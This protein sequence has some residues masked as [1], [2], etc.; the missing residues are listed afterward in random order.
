MISV[1]AMLGLGIT[2]IASADTVWWRTEGGTVVELRD[3]RE[4][5]LFLTD[6]DKSHGVAFTW[7]LDLERIGIQ[8]DRL[9]LSDGQTA[10]MSVRIG[11]TPIDDFVAVGTN[12]FASGVVTQSTEPLLRSA[13]KIT[14]RVNDIELQI[15]VNQSKMPALLTAVDKCRQQQR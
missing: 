14:L 2:L 15:A 8:D 5:I 1:P 9:L 11:N 10:Q 7:L 13:D 3:T 12:G 4:C 6:R